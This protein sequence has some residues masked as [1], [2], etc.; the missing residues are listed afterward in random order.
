MTKYW[1]STHILTFFCVV[2][3]LLRSS[4]APISFISLLC[5]ARNDFIN[6]LAALRT[7]LLPMS[8]SN[9]S[10]VDRISSLLHIHLLAFTLSPTI[11][12]IT[13]MDSNRLSISLCC[14]LLFHMLRRSVRFSKSSALHRLRFSF[15]S[16]T[17][18]CESICI[19]Q[20]N[21]D[22]RNRT[23]HSMLTVDMLKNTTK[24]ANRV[25]EPL[26]ILWWTI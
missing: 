5:T 15:I 12:S 19:S 7:C 4:N 23:T 10:G 1:C 21:Y 3:V 9:F 26:V 18:S 22:P 17:R 20:V 25:V 6:S 16:A 24:C 2:N 8:L 14:S 13:Y 11:L